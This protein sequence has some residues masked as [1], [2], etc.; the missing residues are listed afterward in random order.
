MTTHRDAQRHQRGISD[1]S[2]AKRVTDQCYQVYVSTPRARMISYSKTEE[3]AITINE[4]GMLAPEDK[5]LA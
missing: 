5:E 4:L 1:I 3:I 2:A